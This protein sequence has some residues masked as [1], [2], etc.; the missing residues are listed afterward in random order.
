MEREGASLECAQYIYKS[1]SMVERYRA[2]F[3]ILMTRN[4][5]LESEFKR[6]FWRCS[7][8][9]IHL[10]PWFYSWNSSCIGHIPLMYSVSKIY[11]DILRY[12]NVYLLLRHCLECE[13]FFP[14]SFVFSV[15]MNSFLWNSCT[16]PVKFL[17]SKPALKL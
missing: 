3:F 9:C 16:I 14:C 12:R 10:F 17:R 8:I 1:Y 13:N 4:D 5:N 7:Y 6:K 11:C 15:K 2:W